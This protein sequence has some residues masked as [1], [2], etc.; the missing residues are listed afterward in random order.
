MDEKRPS[1]EIVLTNMENNHYSAKIMQ[2]GVCRMATQAYKP[3][4][5][6]PETVTK[7]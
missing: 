5:F 7:Y 6:G 1:D 3:N 2:K 4:D